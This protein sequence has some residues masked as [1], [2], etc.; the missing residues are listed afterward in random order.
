MKKSMAMLSAL[1]LFAVIAVAQAEDK[2]IKATCPVSGGVAKAEHVLEHQGKKVYFCCPKCPDAF[3]K[4]AGKFAA[5]TS[6]QLAETGQLLQVACPISGEPVDASTAVTIGNAK[7]AFCCN[8]C[9]GKVEGA[10][11]DDQINLVFAK[12]D[13]GFTPQ[14]LCPVSGKAIKTDVSVEHEGKKVYFCCPGCPGAFQKDPAKFLPKLPQ[15]E[16][17]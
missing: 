17:K 2:A 10:S 14:T 6:L 11:K 5:K 7:V 12:A 13:K 15:F 9:K 16:K 4:D 8:N 1:A 3:K